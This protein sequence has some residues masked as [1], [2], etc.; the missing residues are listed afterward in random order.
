M[1]KNANS[2]DDQSSVSV[3]WVSYPQ[4]TTSPDTLHPRDC[5]F[6]CSKRGPPK[7]VH[8]WLVYTLQLNLH[9]VQQKVMSHVNLENLID[10]QER[11]ITNRKCRD[12]GVQGL[13]FR[14]K[15]VTFPACF[16]WS[17]WYRGNFPFLTRL[18]PK[19]IHHGQKAAPTPSRLSSHSG[20]SAKLLKRKEEKEN[21]LS[22]GSCKHKNYSRIEG[23]NTS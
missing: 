4:K 18:M 8:F 13:I 5:L 16:D 1:K 12:I 20:S 15:D 21:K 3:N 6:Y 7:R 19:I 9:R 17:G 2:L 11:H 14:H 10:V 22:R 23:F